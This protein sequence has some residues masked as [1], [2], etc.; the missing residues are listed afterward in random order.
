LKK[1]VFIG[2]IRGFNLALSYYPRYFNK[3]SRSSASFPFVT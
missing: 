3:V 2:V 1:S